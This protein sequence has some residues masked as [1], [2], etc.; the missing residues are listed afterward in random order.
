M[1]LDDVD[2]SSVEPA[3]RAPASLVYRPPSYVE[4][5]DLSKLFTA[6]RPL[7]VELGSGDGT[8]LAQWAAQHPERNFL[9]VERLLG[10]LR[11]LDRKGLRAGLANLRLLRIEA[12]YCLT[13]LLPPA[14]VQ[15]LHIYF[16]DP[17]PKRKHH[18]NRLINAAFTESA[19]AAL[20]PG[21]IIYMRTDDRDYFAQMIA[22]FAGHNAFQAVETPMILASLLTDFERGFDARG[23][24]TLRAAYRRS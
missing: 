8:F 7:E 15:A 2:L 9:G 16:P 19:A 5:L 17:W 13:W 22:S 24:A 1:R 14:S 20:A 21:G 3:R 23:V 4:R 12:W 10:R 6:A 18:K 11:K